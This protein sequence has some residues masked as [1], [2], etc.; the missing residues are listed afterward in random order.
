ML[1]EYLGFSYL[2]LSFLYLFVCMLLVLSPR[3]QMCCS[4][5]PASQGAAAWALSAVTTVWPQQPLAGA[6]DAALEQRDQTGI[7]FPEQGTLQF[8]CWQC[9]NTTINT[10]TTLGCALLS[11]SAIPVAGDRK[12]GSLSRHSVRLT[13]GDVSFPRR[14]DLRAFRIY[15]GT[16]SVT[17]CCDR[18]HVMSLSCLMLKYWPRTECLSHLALTGK[19]C[20]HL[21]AVTAY[22][23]F[24]PAS[25]FWGALISVSLTI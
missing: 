14:G 17:Q 21:C 3:L 18:Q 1:K 6:A 11:L 22:N 15:G 25:S 7:S 12:P 2:V 23:C 9:T 19:P 5:S 16:C 24:I 8:L 10:D 13:M 4:G 20:H